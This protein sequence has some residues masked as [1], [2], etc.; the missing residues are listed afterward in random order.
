MIK[1]EQAQMAIANV[2]ESIREAFSSL[3]DHKK[4][5]E[6]MQERED[7]ATA[8]AVINLR[9]DTLAKVELNLLAPLIEEYEYLEN[10][11]GQHEP[12]WLNKASKKRRA[13]F[14]KSMIQG[15]EVE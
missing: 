10:P 7:V 2:I 4:H 14:V 6:N 1:T 12:G 13:D 5:L 3:I 15:L 8:I 11:I 9:L